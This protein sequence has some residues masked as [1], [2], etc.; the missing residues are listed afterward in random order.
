MR[1]ILSAACFLLLIFPAWPQSTRRTMETA[2]IVRPSGRTLRSLAVGPRAALAAPDAAQVLP[3]AP[4]VIQMNLLDAS[5]VT[6]FVTAE[7]LP[8]GT[9][10]S[11]FIM[12]PDRSEIPLEALELTDDAP[13]GSSFDLPQIRNFSSFW[14]AGFLTYGVLVNVG[15]GDLQAAADFPVGFAR[16]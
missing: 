4:G 2:R 10:I 11:P 9:V 5:H 13:A 8:K 12:F 15:N 14:P 7:R 1:P 16:N 6:W 3:Q